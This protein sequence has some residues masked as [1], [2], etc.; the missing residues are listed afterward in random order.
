MKSIGR[1]TVLSAGLACIFAAGASAD[2]IEVWHTP[3]HMKNVNI[4][5]PTLFGGDPF[6]IV[7]TATFHWTR[8]D[9]PSEGSEVPMTFEG[10]CLE[11]N[12]PVEA[13]VVHTY[14]VLTMEEAGYA[15]PVIDALARLWTRHRHH[16]VTIDKSA[17]FQLAIWEIVHDLSAD[18]LDGDFVVNSLGDTRDLAQQWLLE[19]ASTQTPD[20]IPEFRV[21]R[22]ATAQDQLIV[23]PA[24]GAAAMTLSAA[25]V[26]G[27]RRRRR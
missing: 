12:E 26:F 10:F 24:P 27:L 7:P 3:L 16:A 25:A 19:V 23:V 8:V 5:A 13:G 18:L 14:E 21:L 20:D 2:V 4:S 15:G 6:T 11:V 17:A 22:S 9:T 1:L